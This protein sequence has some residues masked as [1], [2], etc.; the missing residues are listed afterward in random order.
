MIKTHSVTGLRY[1]C[2]KVTISDSKAIS[3]LGSGKY[4]K[5]HLKIHGK[6]INTEIL[7][8]Y[9]LDRI[10][11]FS[12]LCIEYSNNYNIVESDEWANLIEENGLTGAV[13]GKNNPSKNPD[14]NIKKSKSLKGKYCGEFANFYGK[15]HTIETRKK[16]SDANRGDNNVMRRR[17]EVL[18]KMK[19]TKN[20][21][22]YKE[23]QRLISI[24]VN[25]RPDVKEKNKNSKLGLKNPAA[26][27][28]VYVLKNKITC[29]VIIGNRFDLV[30]Q[31]KKLNNKNPEIN[32]LTT[33]DI[34]YFLKKN[35]VVN[36]VKGWVKI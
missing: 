31:M 24:E 11:E 9:E 2:K 1:L 29:D 16:M 22:E 15:K 19:L 28:N 35:R 12:K 36:S 10:E 21:P 27:K 34:G 26:D 20:T 3:Y 18:E 6:H 17:P 33:G 4:W 7:L 5:K 14:V 23:K 8:K 25:S 32:I 13:V 30:E